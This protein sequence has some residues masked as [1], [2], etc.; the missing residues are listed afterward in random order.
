MDAFEARVVAA[1]KVIGAKTLVFGGLC[2]CAW[3]DEASFQAYL[4][5][6]DFQMVPPEEPG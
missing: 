1:A 2:L 4:N 5:G 3:E 6:P